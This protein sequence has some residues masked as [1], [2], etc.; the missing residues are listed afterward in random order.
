M[1]ICPGCRAEGELYKACSDAECQRHHRHFIE[2]AGWRADP[3]DELL[4]TLIDSEYLPVAL[5]G[6]GGMGKIYKAYRMYVS[7][8]VALKVLKSEY[9]QDDTLRERFIREAQVILQ[10]DHP[11]IVHVYGCKPV[12]EC[13]TIYMAMELLVGRSMF[14]ILKRTVAP[15]ESLVG[16]FCEI[17]SALGAAHRKG[18]F[19]RDLK[20]EN[21][22]MVKNEEGEEHVKVLDFGFAHLQSADKKLTMAGV[23][24]GTPHY[25][26]PEQAMGSS[27]ITAAVD[28]YALGIIMFQAISGHLPYDNDKNDLM[29]VMYD[30]VYKETPVCEPRAEYRV[31]NKLL[32]CI[33]KCMKKDPRER[34]ENGDALYKDLKDIAAAIEHADEEYANPTIVTP[35][36][37][38][39]KRKPIEIHL[40]S[41]QKLFIVL[42]VCI[43]LVVLVVYKIMQ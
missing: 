35:A 37:E 42:I 28:I 41:T 15:L 20:P 27:E 11:N 33:D 22:F 18:I 4:G 36:I 31:P 6:E 23:A 21:I 40:T 24:F 2:E 39:P 38:A 19:H 7:Q 43:L 10:L 9:M 3:R 25:M 1:A 17:S 16:W 5:I 14:D 12:P 8:I 29:A 34:Y 30:Q 13:N 32:D 26:S